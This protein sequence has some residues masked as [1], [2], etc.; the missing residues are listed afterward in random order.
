MI[1]YFLYYLHVIKCD[2]VSR[3]HFPAPFVPIKYD[4]YS[5]FSY[6]GTNALVVV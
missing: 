2:F 4:K 1:I 6:E 5:Y 3:D